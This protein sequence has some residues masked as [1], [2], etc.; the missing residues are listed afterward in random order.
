MD[1]TEPDR[2]ELRR[3][4][5]IVRD[6]ERQQPFDLPR[7]LLARIDGPWRDQRLTRSTQLWRRP[8]SNECA[9][10]RAAERALKR[11]GLGWTKA[12]YDAWPIVVAVVIRPGA[13]WWSWCRRHVKTDPLAALES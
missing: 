10:T 2:W 7:T 8:T 5:V 1:L 12:P 3:P 9:R 11:L 6:L 13:C 4:D